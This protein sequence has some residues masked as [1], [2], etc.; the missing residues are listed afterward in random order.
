MFTDW[1]VASSRVPICSAID[2]NRLL[3]I[4]NSTGSACGARRGLRGR[5]VRSSSTSA[6]SAVR[7]ARQPS[8]TT[9]VA[10]ASAMIAGPVTASQVASVPGGAGARHATR[11]AV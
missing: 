8:S 6:R 11:R 1:A 2:M 9:V 7:L 5:A 3:K 4:S 10:L